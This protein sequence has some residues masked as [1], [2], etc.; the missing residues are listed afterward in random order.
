MKSKWVVFLLLVVLIVVAGFLIRHYGLFDNLIRHE[1]Q[2]RN[3]LQE[4]PL[5]GFVIGLMSY[6]ILSL[7]PGT[8]G[9]SVI[10]G[11]LFGFWQAVVIA[12]VA[13]TGAA[14]VTFLVSRWLMRDALRSRFAIVMQKL[15]KHLQ[16][17]GAFYLLTLRLMHSPYTATNY[18]CGATSLSTFSFWWPTQLGLIPSTMV[19]VFAG[20]QI[21]TL[22]EVVEQGATAVFSP[23]LF[24]ALV[25]M[26]IFPLVVR[27]LSNR[28]WKTHPEEVLPLDE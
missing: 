6:F 14:V 17:D 26:G 27:W 13:L 12:D 11:W 7:I 22:R 18:A 21:P 28:Y 23:R 16:K 10:Y 2:I 3:F 19:F 24:L 5:Q 8:G 15:D 25:L 4:S 20:T 9:K 1:V